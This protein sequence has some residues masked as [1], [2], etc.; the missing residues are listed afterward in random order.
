[1]CQLKQQCQQ[2]YQTGVKQRT[3]LDDLWSLEEEM[4][5]RKVHNS[6]IAGPSKN[7]FNSVFD[8]SSDSTLEEQSKEAIIYDTI[9]PPSPKISKGG[10]I[11]KSKVSQTT[12]NMS[13]KDEELLLD[14][15][16]TASHIDDTDSSKSKA[17]QIY[18]YDS[19]VPAEMPTAKIKDTTNNA[20]ELSSDVDIA[21]SGIV[22][23]GNSNSNLTCGILDRNY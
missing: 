15:D 1:M 8:Y 12:E 14:V 21:P 7:N 13:K 11:K 3:A 2:K 9:H 19:D 4:K 23:Q 16:S 5:K 17:Q 10:T 18:A 22:A 20:D 6:Q